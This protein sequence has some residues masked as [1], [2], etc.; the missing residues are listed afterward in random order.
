MCLSATEIHSYTSILVQLNCYGTLSYVHVCTIALYVH[1]PPADLTTRISILDIAPTSLHRR[2][3]LYGN[4]M[5]GGGESSTSA[6]P[7]RIHHYSRKKRSFPIALRIEI[8][9]FLYQLCCHGSPVIQLWSCFDT[10]VAK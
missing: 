8:S 4:G 10:K 3:R 6:Y 2:H 1:C 7:N 9:L 5:L